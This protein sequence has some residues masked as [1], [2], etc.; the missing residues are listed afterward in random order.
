MFAKVV[1]Y[2][3]LL[4]AFWTLQTGFKMPFPV[5]ISGHCTIKF[6]F[7]DITTVVADVVMEVC[8]MP[9][10]NVDLSV[11]E[12]S[13]SVMW[14]LLWKICLE[15]S[16]Y[17]KHIWILTGGINVCHISNICELYY[18]YSTGLL[19]KN[20]LFVLSL[21]RSA[22]KLPKRYLQKALASHLNINYP[23]TPT[24]CRHITKPDS[25][26]LTSSS[27]ENNV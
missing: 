23:R 18:I 13:K 24:K 22:Q 11:N 12:T 5:I 4:R 25:W 3:E 10:K 9:A 16:S 1:W 8:N 15:L 26:K 17:K 20:D 14:K 21:N 19:F 2:F 27:L 7:T 6:L